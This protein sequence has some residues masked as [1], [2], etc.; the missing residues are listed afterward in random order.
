M[1][2]VFLYGSNISYLFFFFE[3][4]SSISKNYAL[5]EV[6]LTENQIGNS[7]AKAMGGALEK[8]ENLQTLVLR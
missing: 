1:Y 8:N 3:P 5:R 4:D 2:R 7:G 6:I